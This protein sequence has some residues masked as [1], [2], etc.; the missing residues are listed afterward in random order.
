M[1]GSDSK[2]QMEYWWENVPPETA[3]NI[4]P[5][6]AL[7][8]GDTT[9]ESQSNSVGE[10]LQKLIS[11]AKLNFSKAKVMCPCGHVCGVT[12]KSTIPIRRPPLVR[13]V[14]DEATGGSHPSAQQVYPAVSVSVT[15]M[16]D[17][18]F[19]RPLLAPSH[20]KPLSKVGTAD[21]FKAQLDKFRPRYCNRRGRAVRP[22]NVVVQ[23]MLPLL[24]KA[25]NGHAMV[26]L[27]V[28]PQTSQLSGEFM[29]IEATVATTSQQSHSHPAPLRPRPIKN[30][31]ILPATSNK[32]NTGCLLVPSNNSD[33]T[34]VTLHQSVCGNSASGVAL[35]QGGTSHATTE[36]SLHS[37]VSGNDDRLGIHQVRRKN[38]IGVGLPQHGPSMD[39]HHSVLGS[40]SAVTVGLHRDRSSIDDSNTQSHVPLGLSVLPLNTP[41]ASPPSISNLLELSLPSAVGEELAVVTGS[42][43]TRLL[44]AS[45]P[46]SSATAQPSFV[47]LLPS[48]EGFQ[49]SVTPPSSPLRI[50]KEADNQWLNSEV[51]DFSLSSF[52][53]HLESPLKPATNVQNTEDTRLFSDVEAQL[54][55]LMSENSIDYMA[56]FADLAAQIASSDTSNKK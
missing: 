52:L 25:P 2:L 32:S 12:S 7:V 48:E 19:R 53:G 34:P 5:L 24:P 31:H 3:P 14:V 43:S 55:C 46:D 38:N 17:G 49:N 42:G 15:T 18:V 39:L 44:D 20:F 26:T 41:V 11:I 1:F 50:L 22:K 27:K 9:L 28:I 13:S 10:T 35:H 33:V 29:P 51:A 4:M 37:A 45:V 30:H 47:G 6:Q 56:K 23:R 21:A 54:Q 40:S 36:S 16:Q 8:E